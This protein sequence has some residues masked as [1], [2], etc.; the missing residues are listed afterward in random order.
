MDLTKKI[1]KN[2]LTVVA[3]SI[4][5]A[6]VTPLCIP[7]VVSQ[8]YEQVEVT[9]VD[10]YYRYGYRYPDSYKI[11]VVYDGKEYTI[12]DYKTYHKY[13]YS[14]GETTMATLETTEYDNGRLKLKITEL[15]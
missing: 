3:L 12:D 6:I 9:V 11:T 5:I 2:V 13:M 4:I 1:K 7:E 10:E 15:E 14:V 8:N